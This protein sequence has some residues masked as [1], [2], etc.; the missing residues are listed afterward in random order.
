MSLTRSDEACKALIKRFPNQRY[1]FYFKDR[2][3]VFYAIPKAH[4]IWSLHGQLSLNREPETVAKYGALHCVSEMIATFDFA[5]KEGEV[6][7]ERIDRAEKK[8][9]DKADE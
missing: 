2:R 6:D 9:Y 5:M 3:E 4:G 7:N 1:D 8:C